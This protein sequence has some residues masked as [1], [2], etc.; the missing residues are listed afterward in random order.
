MGYHESSHEIY[1]FMLNSQPKYQQNTQIRLCDSMTCLTVLYYVEILDSYH[2]FARIYKKVCNLN[3]SLVIFIISYHWIVRE[4]NINKICLE[5]R[6][7]ILVNLR[8]FTFILWNYF[9]TVKSQN[10]CYSYLF[11]YLI[12]PDQPIAGQFGY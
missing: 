10:S 1:Q 2:T 7:Q 11:F 4:D 8:K 12:V 5:R 6:F 9:I 3:L